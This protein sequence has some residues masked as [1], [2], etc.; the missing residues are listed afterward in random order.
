[1][2]AALAQSYE[3]GD[4][5]GIRLA[6]KH[7]FN[8]LKDESG[9][10]AQTIQVEQ[11]SKSESKEEAGPF[12]EIYA[13]LQVSQMSSSEV[14]HK[15]FLHKL[16]KILVK[17]NMG[18]D[19]RLPLIRELQK[20]WISHDILTDTVTRT[21]YDFRELGVRGLAG[22]V[23]HTAPED[24]L[25]LKLSTRTPLRIGELLQ[26]AG[27]LET[28]ELEIACDM[29]KAMPEMR[30]GSFLVKQGFI[31][32]RDLESVLVGQSLIRMA[33]ISIAQYQVAMELAHSR[34]VAISEILTER[35]YTKRDLVDEAYNAIAA[36][37]GPSESP[38]I[39]ADFFKRSSSDK[40]KSIG[41]LPVIP[42]ADNK[43]A[44]IESKFDDVAS[45]K[46]LRKSRSKKTQTSSSKKNYSGERT[47]K[48]RTIK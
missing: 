10:S 6:H 11:A 28:S 14:V 17:I 13:L 34:G 19:D 38:T 35:R 37:A 25:Q 22:Q 24:Q 16:R 48:K 18:K 33:A 26:C 32:E 23:T 36:M 40:E 15:S 43:E 7:I 42:Q 31:Q 1:M 29:H 3:R 27:L 41:D 5:K 20:L 21:D 47:T 4:L 46:P 12:A 39:S 45:N 2:A 44:P 8:L 30:F 9:K